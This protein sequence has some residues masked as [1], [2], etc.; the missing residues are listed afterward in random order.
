M[1]QIVSM[2]EQ[3]KTFN[4]F[5]AY[6]GSEWSGEVGL[7]LP[8][9]ANARDAIVTSGIARH[10]KGFPIDAVVCGVW[11]KVKSLDYVLREGDRVEIYRPL[12]ADPKDA[13]RAKVNT[14]KR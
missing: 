12:Q 2:D 8:E 10:L 4:V 1:I 7:R 13:R 11:G 14:K 5:V 3:V 9:G 6:S